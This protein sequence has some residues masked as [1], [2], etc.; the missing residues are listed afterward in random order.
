MPK[1][2]GGAAD[3]QNGAAELRP[4]V[5]RLPFSFESYD[6]TEPWMKCRLE[7]GVCISCKSMACLVTKCCS[8]PVQCAVCIFPFNSKIEAYGTFEHSSNLCKLVYG[9]GM[10]SRME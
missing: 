5:I 8:I 2:L 9:A 1:I 7:G 3:M 10:S 6:E 4:S